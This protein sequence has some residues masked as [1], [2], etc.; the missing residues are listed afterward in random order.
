MNNEGIITLIFAV[1][2]EALDFGNFLENEKGY[3]VE[4]TLIRELYEIP[5]TDENE[6][7]QNFAKVDGQYCNSDGQRHMGLILQGDEA[8]PNNSFNR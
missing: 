2:Q 5:E 4:L 6:K 7:N 8:Q 3:Q 1:K